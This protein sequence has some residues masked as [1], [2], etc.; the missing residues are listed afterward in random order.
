MAKLVDCATIFQLAF[1]VNAILPAIVIAYRRTQTNIVR[2]VSKEVDKHRPEFAIDESEMADFLDFATDLHHGLKSLGWA[3]RI[4]ITACM[5]SLVVSFFGLLFAA[6]RPDAHLSNGL[7]WSFAIYSLVICPSL[8]T[9]YTGLLRFEEKELVKLWVRERTALERLA[10][11]FRKMKDEEK[12]RFPDVAS[13]KKWLEE[14]IERRKGIL[15]ETRWGRFLSK[16][17][18]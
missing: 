13:E 2:W 7:L 3:K 17:L 15:R 10:A 5:I 1:G 8:A 4:P 14:E 9:W 16:R 12:A 11:A 18:P 6:T